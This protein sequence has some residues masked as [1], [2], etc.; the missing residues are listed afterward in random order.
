MTGK[1]FVEQALLRVQ[2]L[3]VV[4]DVGK[5]YDRQGLIVVADTIQALGFG[6][7]WRKNFSLPLIVVTGSVATTPMIFLVRSYLPGGQL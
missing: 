7:R 6:I 2:V 1:Q 3:M 4:S 5:Q